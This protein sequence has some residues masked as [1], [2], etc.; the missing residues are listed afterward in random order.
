MTPGRV[1]G[2]CCVGRGRGSY[3]VTR[4][5]NLGNGRYK[6]HTNPVTGQRN[7]GE[8]TYDHPNSGGYYLTNN[9]DYR[10]K[11]GHGR[12]MS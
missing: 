3:Y 6:D 10:L 9:G 4:Q 8:P 2:C 1:P 12:T 11:D 5:S 7:P